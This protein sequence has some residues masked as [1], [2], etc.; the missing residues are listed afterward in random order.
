MQRSPQLL[1]YSH[2]LQRL[3]LQ[4]I[5]T[6]TATATACCCRMLQRCVL[7]RLLLVLLL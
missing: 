1:R 3:L 7:R 4:R 2:K 6:A 5:C